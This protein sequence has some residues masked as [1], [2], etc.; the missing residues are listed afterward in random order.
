MPGSQIPDNLNGLNDNMSM[1]IKQY[2]ELLPKNFIGIARIW[3]K[4]NPPQTF[5]ILPPRNSQMHFE[6]PVQIDPA[7]LAPEV[8]EGGDTQFSDAEEKIE[9]FVC[10]EYRLGAKITQRAMQFGIARIV[11]KRVTQ[12]VDAVNRS[13]EFV[14]IQALLGNNP[15]Q[16]LG[17]TRL[18]TFEAG[19]PTGAS[20]PWNDSNAVIIKDILRA[21][22]LVEIKSGMNATDV[23]VPYDEYEA[24]HDD[25][26]IMEQLKYTSG[27]LLTG[28]QITMIKGLRVHVMKNFY[29]SR[30][31]RTPDEKIYMLQD[32]VIVTTN[33]PGWTAVAEP[34]QGTAPQVIRW[35]EEKSRSVLAHAFSTMCPVIEDYGQICI[36][37]NTNAN[38]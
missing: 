20:H 22:K 26:K 31:G 6:W 13:R 32:K 8:Q 5:S 21:K 3:D 15:N 10:S 9:K 24:I 11:E 34:Q 18:N 19:D 4:A 29:K 12:L 28:G 38:I 16:P 27:T 7:M 14:N 25:D 37:T 36:I 33:T 17:V 23:F 35:P 1:W 2:P 30:K